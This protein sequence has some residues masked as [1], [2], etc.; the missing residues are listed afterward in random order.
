MIN[1]L[2]DVSA[3]VALALVLLSMLAAASLLVEELA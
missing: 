1:R 3:Y 2:L